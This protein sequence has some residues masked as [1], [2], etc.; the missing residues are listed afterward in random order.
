MPGSETTESGL[1]GANE[2]NLGNFMVSKRQG[3]G[4]SHTFARCLIFGSVMLYRRTFGKHYALPGRTQQ[5][6]K[7]LAPELRQGLW[8]IRGKDLV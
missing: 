2:P 3:Y 7:E 8:F 6:T 5:Q 1:A 4:L